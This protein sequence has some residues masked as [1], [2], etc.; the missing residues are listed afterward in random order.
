LLSFI[1]A[2]VPDA[3]NR[4]LNHS[5]SI[6]QGVFFMQKNLLAALVLALTLLCAT[7]A[8]AQTAA[9]PAAPV[10]MDKAVATKITQL[11]E[12]STQVY[13]KAKD[14]VWVVKFKGNHLA[15][16]SVIV[17]HSEGL[18]VMFAP[19]AEKAEYKAAPELLQKLLTLNDDYD[20]VKVAIDSDGDLLL[21][22]D[23]TFR[24]A[25]QK[26]FN[27]NLEQVSTTADLTYQVIKP[28]LL[29]P[30]KAAN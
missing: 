21:R 11:L 15:D 23:F 30:K 16:I 4:L 26:E 6:T 29:A 24:L 9:A 27:A 18:L 8:S 1:S 19:I 22:S 25:D 17:V 13:T 7:T 10:A 12:G 28:F 20:R 3:R 14:G 2:P 5:R